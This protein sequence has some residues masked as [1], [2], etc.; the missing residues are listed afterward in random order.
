MSEQEAPQTTVQVRNLNSYYGHK[1]GFLQ[2]LSLL[3]NAGL[4]VYAHIGLSGII[5]SNQDPARTS[6]VG[7]TINDTGLSGLCNEQDIA[8]WTD[9][10]G[11]AIRPTH[12]TFCSREYNGGVCLT[13]AEC[14]E[15]CFQTT[16]G[17]SDEC[18][19]CFGGIPLCSLGQGC[20]LTCAGNS[21]GSECQECNAECIAQMKVCSGL[22]EVAV[23]NGTR[24]L[25]STGNSSSFCNEYNLDEINTWYT[26]Y[27]LTFVGSIKDA[28]Y[29]D[30]KLLAVIVI[31]FSGIWPYAKNVILLLV[32]YIPMSIEL[33]TSTI[34]WLSRLSKYTLVDFFA[35]TVVIL[36]VQLQLDVGGTEAVI[37]AEPRFGI[38]AF[39]L[40]T[41]WE[42]VQIEVMKAMHEDK[43]LGHGKSSDEEG[44]EGDENNNGN[45]VEER[46]LFSQLWIP[47]VILV[48]SIGLYIAGAVTEIVQFTS[49]DINAESGCTKSY[50]LVTLADALIND[51]GLTDN[52][53]AWQTWILYCVYMLLNLALPVL[54]HLLQIIFMVRWRKKTST[55]Q[56]QNLIRLSQWTSAFWCFACVEVLLIGI[57]AVEFKFSKLIK[58]IAG[59]SNAI[60]LD[61]T[62]GLGPGFYLLIAYSVAAG[63]LQRS[64]CITRPITKNK[65][66]TDD[67]AKREG[68]DV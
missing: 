57:F 42:F 2:S 39:F 14:I 55:E 61:I 68:N 54:V 58:K 67:I 43:V 33:Q 13:N 21:L 7:D 11:D 63:F 8:L 34:L 12:S 15:E 26:V 62:S 45:S 27:D 56:L 65:E 59:S 36:G 66:E 17:Y 16:Y 6:V 41:I 64:L 22:P 4:M 40:A 25:Q 18:S 24:N 38:I 53:A 35:V 44:N 19:S 46:L 1:I 20:A 3:L 52:A 32:W 37:R 10:G 49:T 50:N 23:A 5:L 31:I 29:G 51:L 60:F 28:W 47:P 48:A 30:A 9:Y